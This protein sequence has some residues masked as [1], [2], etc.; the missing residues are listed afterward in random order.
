MWWG[1]LGTRHSEKKQSGLGQ[2]WKL[3]TKPNAH[4]KAR[5]AFAFPDD[6][7]VRRPHTWGWT[8]RWKGSL[9]EWKGCAE[10]CRVPL[11]LRWITSKDLPYLAG[12]PLSA[13]GSLDGRGVWGRVNTRTRTAESLCCPPKPAALFI[14]YAPIWVS[15]TRSGVSFYQQNGKNLLVSMDF[16]TEE[17]DLAWTRATFLQGH[18]ACARSDS[19]RGV[20]TWHLP[21]RSFWILSCVRVLSVQAGFPV[22]ITSR[23]AFAVLWPVSRVAVSPLPW[24]TPFTLWRTPSTSKKRHKNVYFLCFL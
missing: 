3:G 7:P 4:P 12:T 2:A 14:G 20:L 19:R 1:L 24:F 15:E 18:A 9:P 10:V 5:G 21:C 16:S 6:T 22:T 11:H 17:I 8:K 23:V 13:V